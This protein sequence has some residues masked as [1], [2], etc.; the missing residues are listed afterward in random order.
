MWLAPGRPTGLIAKQNQSQVMA[1]NDEI[2]CIPST[3]FQQPS[4]VYGN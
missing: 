4:G 3:G 1:K 2:V